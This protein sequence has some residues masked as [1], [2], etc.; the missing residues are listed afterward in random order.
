M[1]MPAFCACGAVYGF[2][3]DL[4]DGV[5]GLTM[6][7]NKAQCPVCGEMG[8]VPDGVFN[9]TDGVLE[10][11]SAPTITHERLRRLQA[12]LLSAKEGTATVDDAVDRLEREAPELAPFMGSLHRE[13]AAWLAI[14]LTVITFLLGQS[15]G[16][17]INVEHVT[18]TIIQECMQHPA[19]AV[20]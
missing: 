17:T 10:V 19:R 12:I 2:G 3:L 8:E 4:G 5:R 18:Q 9:V 14:L 16:T 15:A 7:G 20:P 11:L 6:T 13:P 1:E